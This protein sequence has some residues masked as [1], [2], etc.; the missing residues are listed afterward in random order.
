MSALQVCCAMCQAPAQA[1]CPR[2]EQP[3][4]A[5]HALA[6]GAAHCRDCERAVEARER[7]RLGERVAVAATAAIGG[8]IVGAILVMLAAGALGLAPEIIILIMLVAELGAGGLSAYAADRGMQRW[9][10]RR[11][12]TELG[13][14]PEARLLDRH[15]HHD[16]S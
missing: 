12:G 5:E 3:L 2:C 4:C 7:G 15:D 11:A 1:R 14:L 6:P 13:S 16:D 10:R 9:L 8:M